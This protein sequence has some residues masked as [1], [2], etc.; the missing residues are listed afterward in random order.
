MLCIVTPSLGPA[1]PAGQVQGQE[2]LLS[3][4]KDLASWAPICLAFLGTGDQSSL[5][6]GSG[7]GLAEARTV[8]T[9]QMMAAGMMTS[10]RDPTAGS[11]RQG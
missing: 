7:M 1:V 2:G 11:A 4:A 9:S 8:P 6:T 10:A 5:I 3:W